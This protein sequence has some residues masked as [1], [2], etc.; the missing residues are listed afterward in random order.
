MRRRIASLVVCFAL[1]ASSFAAAQ[2]AAPPKAAGKPAGAAAP[3]K[4]LLRQILTAW[5]SMNT[6]NVAKYYDQAPG[7]VFYD[8]APLKY[9]GFTQYAEGVTSMFAS[10]SALKFTLNDDVA[11]HHMGSW[12]WCT[13][14]VKAAMTDKAGKTENVDARWTA[15]FEKKGAGWVIVHDHFSAPAPEPPK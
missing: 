1:A 7:D 2:A 9:Q 13:A 11:V 5:E 3:D 14:T 8:I 15:I 4:A 12:A 10:L 6:D